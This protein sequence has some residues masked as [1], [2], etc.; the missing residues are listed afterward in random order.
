MLFGKPF[1]NALARLDNVSSKLFR[2]TSEARG[3]VK[4]IENG[5]LDFGKAVGDDA[6]KLAYKRL[7]KSV[8]DTCRVVTNEAGHVR[9]RL[10]AKDGRA[11]D[12]GSL[13]KSV[14]TGD[15][16]RLMDTMR[17]ADGPALSSKSFRNSFRNVFTRTFPDARVEEALKKRVHDRVPRR[18]YD[19]PVSDAAE[20]MKSDAVLRQMVENLADLSKRSRRPVVSKGLFLTIAITGGTTAAVLAA[21]N[22]AAEKA[23]GCWRVYREGGRLKKCLSAHASCTRSDT[24]MEDACLTYPAVHTADVCGERDD[25]TSPCARCDAAAAPSSGNYL[26]TDDFVDAA[27]MY[28]C[29]AK[30]SLGDVLGHLAADVPS[31]LEETATS[32]LKSVWNVLKGVALYAIVFVVTL[33]AGFFAYRTYAGGE[34]ARKE[35]APKDTS[36]VSAPR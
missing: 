19:A 30:P 20:L 34:A 11:I 3:F 4:Q 14:R 22:V 2:T 35:D 31:M 33:L 5:F 12:A 32:A 16:D 7:F 21:L 36:A 9:I 29:Q 1:F 24:D 8:L 23:V 18:L 28:V 17:I 6:T 13:V 15:L 26:D 25:T 27:D 10:F